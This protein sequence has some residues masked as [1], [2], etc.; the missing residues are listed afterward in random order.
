MTDVKVAADGV[1][2][3]Q[4][5]AAQRGAICI[6]TIYERPKSRPTAFVARR[7]E[8]R[9]VKPAWGNHDPAQDLIAADIEGLRAIFARAGLTNVGRQGPD[10]PPIVETWL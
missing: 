4:W 10:K 9:G 5:E 2:R 3:A 1:I 8:V 6:W 7:F